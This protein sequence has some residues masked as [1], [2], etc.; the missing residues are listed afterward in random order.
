MRIQKIIEK[1]IKKSIQESIR[2]RIIKS[3]IILMDHII[4]VYE[5]I[6][7]DMEEE[8]IMMIKDKKCI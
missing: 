2:K 7:K 1:R 8:S 5:K 3:I 6:K 4:V